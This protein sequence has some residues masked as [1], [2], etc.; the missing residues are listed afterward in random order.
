MLT[1]LGRF[2]CVKNDSTEYLKIKTFYIETA[3]TSKVA[4]HRLHIT[5]EEFQLI[6]EYKKLACIPGRGRGGG[7]GGVPWVAKEL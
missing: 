3:F 2:L 6:S 4:I 5:A 7:G 1:F